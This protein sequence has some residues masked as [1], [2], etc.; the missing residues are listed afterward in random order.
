MFG[1][2]HP[3]REFSLIWR[4][5]QCRW[6]AA[7]FDLCLALMVIEQWGFFR[8]SNPLWQGTTVFN[9]YL[10]GLVTLTPI[11][12]RLAVKLSLPVLTTS[13]FRGCDSNTQTSAIG[14]NALTH[15]SIAVV[16]ILK[17]SR[18]F[19]FKPSSQDSSCLHPGI[20]QTNYV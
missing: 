2:Y 10:R 17:K 13:V 5:H 3:T 7:N 16:S 8:V 9:G 15:C 1:V 12:G 20:N 19:A 18:L 11:A 6:R 4:R 14:A